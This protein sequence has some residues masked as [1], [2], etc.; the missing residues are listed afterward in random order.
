MQVKMQMAMIKFKNKM[1]KRKEK[2]TTEL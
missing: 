1:E 2:I